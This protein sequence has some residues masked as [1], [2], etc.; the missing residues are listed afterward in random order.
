MSVM[1]GITCKWCGKA[2]HGT[3]KC[4]MLMNLNEKFDLSKLDEKERVALSNRVMEAAI[5]G[6]FKE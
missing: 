1:K 6:L 4:P 3:A 5:R 2:P